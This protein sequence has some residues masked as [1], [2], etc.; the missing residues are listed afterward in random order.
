[1]ID[2]DKYNISL[3]SPKDF[4]KVQLSNVREIE[5]ENKFLKNC[6]LVGGILL[7]GYIFYTINEINKSKEK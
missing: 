2:I 5:T 4:D 6:L 3:A 7:M 1:M